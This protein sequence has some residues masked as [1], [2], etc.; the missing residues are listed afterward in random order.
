MKFRNIYSRV[1]VFD[2]G[3]RRYQCKDGLIDAGGDKELEKFLKKNPC[4]VP[5]EE[6][7]KGTDD[8]GDDGLDDL[9]DE[10]L[11]ALIVEK[12]ILPPST[13]DRIK[14]RESLI[15]KIREAGEE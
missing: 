11:R 3:D 10:E 14:N 5:C 12:G 2:F 1:A 15:K 7:A 4:F 6:E 13:L 9:T 8:S